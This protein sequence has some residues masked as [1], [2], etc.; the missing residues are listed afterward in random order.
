M[1]SFKTVTAKQPKLNDWQVEGLFLGGQTFFTISPNLPTI[2]MVLTAP[3]SALQKPNWIL[4]LRYLFTV[5]RQS[6]NYLKIQSSPISK[7]V[8]C[9]LSSFL[10]SLSLFCNQKQ[11]KKRKKIENTKQWNKNLLATNNNYINVSKKSNYH[12]IY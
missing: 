8:T 3:F 6:R 1:F 9:Q 7:S 12:T 10:N 5:Q 11:K 2:P 4:P